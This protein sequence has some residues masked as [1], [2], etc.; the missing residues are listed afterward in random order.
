MYDTRKEFI[1]KKVIILLLTLC[2][3]F[4]MAA[5]SE[6]EPSKP[7]QTIMPTQTPIKEYILVKTKTDIPKDTQI[8]EDNITAFFEE[9]KTTEPSE[10]GSNVQWDNLKTDILHLWTKDVVPSGTIINPSMFSITVPDGVLPPTDEEI[11]KD[12]VYDKAYKAVLNNDGLQLNIDVA[13]LIN[14]LPEEQQ[15]STSITIQSVQISVFDKDKSNQN[16]YTETLTGE[17]DLKKVTG[18]INFK[19]DFNTEEI[20]SIVPLENKSLLPLVIYSEYS[21]KNIK[22]PLVKISANVSVDKNEYQIYIGGTFTMDVDPSIDVTDIGNLDIFDILLNGGASG[23][24]NGDL[25]NGLFDGLFNGSGSNIF[26][27]DNSS[28]K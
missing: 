8:T 24:L 5:C 19:L 6:K 20:K 26:F 27:G 2:M 13:D 28:A 21:K 22:D 25:F 15:K 23:N 3:I 14:A 16:R 12:L 4:S 11:E 17:Y 10:V 18:Q 7:S 1:M 9:Y